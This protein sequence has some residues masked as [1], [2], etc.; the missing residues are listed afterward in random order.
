MHQEGYI[1]N[2]LVQIY[3]CKFLSYR[4][5]WYIN[6]YV[7]CE[8]N[9]TVWSKSLMD[10]ILWIRMILPGSG[11]APGRW[12]GLLLSIFELQRSVIYQFVCTL[13]DKSNG[14]I[15][16]SYGHHLWNQ[17]DPSCI[18][19]VSWKLTIS[20]FVN[21]W[22]TKKCDISICMYI[23]RQIQWCCQNY[24]RTSSLVSR[25]SSMDQEEVLKD[26]QIRFCQIFSYREVW[27]INLYVLFDTNPMVWSKSLMY[28]ILGIKK[29][30]YG[31]RKVPKRWPDLLLST[32]E[33]QRS[34][35][36]KFVCTLWDQ[37]NGVVKTTYGHH[38]W[39]QE[40]FILQF[41]PM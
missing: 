3:F 40:D 35:I 17:E 16:I 24:L 22:A 6:L 13:R 31:W 8:T 15:K 11:R 4:E 25:R 21:F 12:P 20:T 18:R 5:V 2:I 39:C 41:L 19:K 26:D 9:P 7:L 29:I 36:Y 38:P 33:L 32:F 37:S 23:A 1:R 30:L 10:I 14:V 28:I 34:V 27:F